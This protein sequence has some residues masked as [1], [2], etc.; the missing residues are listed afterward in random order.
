MSE[1]EPRPSW[2]ISYFDEVGD[3]VGQP[4][5]HCETSPRVSNQIR[6]IVRSNKVSFVEVH[7]VNGSSKVYSEVKDTDPL[8]KSL[9]VLK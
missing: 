7:Y 2:M 9:E 1:A 3:I 8:N 4:T 6:R 5:Y